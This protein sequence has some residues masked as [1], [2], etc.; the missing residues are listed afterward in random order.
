MKNK[1]ACIDDLI[2]FIPLWPNSTT[3]DLSPFTTLQFSYQCSIYVVN[4]EDIIKIISMGL[5]IEYYSSSGSAENDS[6][7]LSKNF[8]LALK[9]HTEKEPTS[10]RIQ[11]LSNT[12]KTEIFEPTLVIISYY[13]NDTTEPIIELSKTYRWWWSG[14]SPASSWNCNNQLQKK[15]SV[16]SQMQEQLFSKERATKIF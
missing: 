1:N 6:C 5:L 11:Y 9:T 3:G 7:P 12:P 14:V 10:V 8:M 15:G 16:F 13:S 4:K 2:Q